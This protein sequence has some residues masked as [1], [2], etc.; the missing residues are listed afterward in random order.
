MNIAD[1]LKAFEEQLLDPAVRG[2]TDFV[3]SL[4]A[5]DFLEFG[6]SG[7]IFDKTSILKNLRD[8]PLHLP[9]LLSDFAIRTL[10]PDAML[11]TYRTTRL[12]SS[13]EPISHARRSS[14]WINRN[15]RWQITFHQGTLSSAP[16]PLS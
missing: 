2:N 11:V 14:I 10:A 1:H 8:E 4:L 5:D 7:R 3:S 9:S 13:G 6:I 16:F 15:N 12:N